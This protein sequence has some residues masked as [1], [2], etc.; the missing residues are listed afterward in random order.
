MQDILYMQL[1]VLLSS[2]LEEVLHSIFFR[3]GAEVKV[4]SMPYRARV[5]LSSLA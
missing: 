4:V 3:V 5:F 2:G 1:G